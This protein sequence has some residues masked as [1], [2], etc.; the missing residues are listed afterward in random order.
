MASPSIEALFARQQG[1]RW[2]VAATS[3]DQR[4]AKLRALL[5]AL[6]AHRAE[7]QA[8]L[9]ADFRKAPEEVDLTELYPVIS[10]LKDALRHLPR[11]MKPRRVPTPIGLLGSAGT[12]IHEPRGVVLIIAPWNY[13]IYL[14][15][16]PLVSALAAGNC[17]VIKPSE[18]TPRTNAFLRKLLGG[19]FPEE[20]VTLVEGEADT[21]QALLALP[22][23]HVF[24][25]GSPAVGK[26][27]MKAAA[28][29]LSS[30]TLEL[31]GKSPVL[32]DADAD[33]ENAARKIAWGK[34]VNA[35][36][37]CV[38]P[39]YVLVHERVH[40]AL[41]EALKRAL[42]DFY[43]AEADTRRL[44]PDLARIIHD[45]HHAR[46]LRLLQDSRGVVVFGGENDP[47]TRYMEPTLLT[48][49]DPA[50]PIMQEEIFGPLLPILKVQDMDAAVAFVNARPKPLAL[51]VFSGSRRNAEALIGRTTAGGGCINDTLLHFAH[52]GLPT[53][54]VN[55]SG[56]GKAHGRHGFETFSNARG[57]LR[58]RTRFSALQLMYPPYTGFVRRLIDLT[59][60]HF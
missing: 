17:A 30:V 15:L 23:D 24:F 58:Q 26:V 57:I 29:H 39:D 14:T 11:W 33:L 13:P 1:A 22:F 18:F 54:G 38:A 31:G 60:K 25:T 56:F 42:V 49:V 59:L 53:G 27:V 37:T 36:Q 45:H 44:N 40:A 5:E 12:I 20:E 41:V 6:M 28:E 2:R 52:T 35:G 3:A 34:C 16:G 21:A 9:A 4:K 51:Y 47:A 46:L 8:A 32:V 55:T 10:E 50:S 7:A 19:L 48:E 43:G